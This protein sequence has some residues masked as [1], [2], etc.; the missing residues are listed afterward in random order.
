MDKSKKCVVCLEK[1]DTA[2]SSPNPSQ[3]LNQAIPSQDTLKPVFQRISEIGSNLN[4]RYQSDPLH[5]Y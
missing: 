1:N 2:Q 3:S 4:Y 5:N